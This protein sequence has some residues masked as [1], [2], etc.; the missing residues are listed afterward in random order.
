MVAAPLLS[1]VAL[2]GFSVPAAPPPRVHVEPR[3]PSPVAVAKCNDLTGKVAFIAGVA[4]STGYGWAICK[5]L[6]N[7]GATIAVGTWPPVLGIF[8]KS[9]STGKFDEDMMLDDGSKMKIDKIYPLDAVF[10]ERDDVPEDVLN[11]KRY[12]GLAGFT[13]QECADA[14][15]A[16]YGKIDIFVHSLANGPEVAKPLLETSRTGYIAAMSASSYSLISCV[17]RFAPIMKPGG[18]ILS[19]GFIAAQQVVPGYGG[20][21][22][23]AKAQVCACT[24]KRVLFVPPF[25]LPSAA[26]SLTFYLSFRACL[27]PARVRHEGSR[28]GGRP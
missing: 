10:D 19:L 24:R 25:S 5:A 13:I 17:Q 18:S 16:D 28:V 1:T 8:Q 20:G 21:M 4:D 7:A 9:L 6:A 22:S 26:C 27:L 12:A 23:S 11:N 14:V 3:A 2:L 15:A